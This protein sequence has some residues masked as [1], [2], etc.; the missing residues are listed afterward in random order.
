MYELKI[1]DK[2]YLSISIPTEKTNILIIQGSKGFLSC[3][4]LS[5]D[6]AN[7]W[8]ESIAI[9]TG[10][11][12]FDEMLNAKIVKVSS[13]AIELGIKIGDF[14]KAALLKLH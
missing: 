1:G 5:I 9:V 6:A 11:K 2:K 14:G 7:K 8:N 4:Y 13:K 10:V 12:N 3:G